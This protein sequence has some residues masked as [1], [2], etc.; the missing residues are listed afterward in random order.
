MVLASATF[1]NREAGAKDLARGK[2]IASTRRGRGFG[3]GL[4][5]LACGTAG[6]RACATHLEQRPALRR[7]NPKWMEISVPDR[8]H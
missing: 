2:G 3:L 4:V 1:K 7:E 8:R 5:D 6:A